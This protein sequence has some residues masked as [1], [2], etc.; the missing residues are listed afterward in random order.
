MKNLPGGYLSYLFFMGKFQLM[1]AY[2]HQKR[3][4]CLMSEMFDRIF[5]P[6]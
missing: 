4:E 3:R 2:I 6:V 1:L 5:R